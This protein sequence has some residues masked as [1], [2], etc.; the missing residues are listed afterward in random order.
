MRRVAAA[1]AVLLA[2]VAAG[3]ARSQVATLTAVVDEGTL[4]LLDAS[5]AAVERLAPGTYTVTVDDRSAVHNVHV[6]GPGVSRDSGL[7]FVGRTVWTIDVRDGVYTVV[8]D[9]QADTL[10]LAVVAGAPP[11]PRLVA[12]VTDSEIA[13]VTTD[14]SVVQQVEPGAYAI[15]VE[16]RSRSESFRLVG[17]GVEQHTQRHVPFETTW[18]VTLAD[19]VYH[20]FS[21]RRPA[22]LRGSLR[23]GA[24]TGSPPARTLEAFTGSDFAIA[25]VGSDFAPVRR[26]ERGT[27]TIRVHDRSPDHNFRL[28]GPGV[29]VATT[30]EGVGDREFEV[31]LPGGTYRFL[32]DPHTLTMLGTFDVPRAAATAR[33]LEATLTAGGTAVLRLASGGVVR[34]LPAGRYDVVVRDRSPRTGFQLI[35]PGVHRATGAAFRGTATWRVRLVRGTYRYGAPPALR[36]LRVR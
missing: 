24:G 30:L 10:A 13:L 2:A 1:V 12:R 16:D 20:Y 14:G 27:Y 23:V 36:R 25:L 33:R 34:T 35:G 32:C 22:A 11:E 7:S 4:R 6:E 9:P 17:P 26:L 31:R 21:D 28:S 5:G 3:S 18:V 19:G 29:D 8:S 15:R